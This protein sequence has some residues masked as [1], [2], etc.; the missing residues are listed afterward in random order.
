MD[1]P[2]QE[3]FLQE[4]T[5]RIHR[6]R[7]VLNLTQ[8]EVG[9]LIGMSRS[10]YARLESGRYARMQLRQLKYLGDVLQTSLDYLLLR[11]DDDPGVI[12]P[13]RC[14]GERRCVEACPLP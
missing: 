12:P 6:R 7:R 13:S 14:P 11:L 9:A 3:E 1:A 10:Q 4:F 5:R 2:S 8:A